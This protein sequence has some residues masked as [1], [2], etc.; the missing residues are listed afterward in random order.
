MI[1]KLVILGAGAAGYVLGA[2]AGRERYEQITQQAQKLRSN[3][4]VQQKVEEAKGVAKETANAATEKV[5]G[6]SD[7]SSSSADYSSTSTTT[8][9]PAGAAT[10][11]AGTPGFGRGDETV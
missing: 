8:A 6:Q 11:T 2:K 9:G 10:T 4:T 3:P 1:K 7:E 5:K